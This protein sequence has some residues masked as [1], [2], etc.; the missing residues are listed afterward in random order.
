M[1][2]E[3]TKAIDILESHIRPYIALPEDAD[4]S[5]WLDEAVQLFLDAN[6][7]PDTR[8]REALEVFVKEGGRCDDMTDSEI[9]TALKGIAMWS[10]SL[11]SGNRITDEDIAWA[12]QSNPQEEQTNDGNDE[13]LKEIA[14]E[15]ASLA[16]SD[17]VTKAGHEALMS[18]GSRLIT[19]SHARG[20]VEDRIKD[21]MLDNAKSRFNISTPGFIASKLGI[22]ASYACKVMRKL[23]REGFCE[24]RYYYGPYAVCD[25]IAE[26][27]E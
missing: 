17:S 13:A 14:L 1:E 11:L 26:A 3:L 2:T 24:Q 4:V 7:P 23:M 18:I 20:S 12:L 25:P 15:I 6:N 27:K 21:L 9:R 5:E 10:K 16:G 22:S 8:M 19:L